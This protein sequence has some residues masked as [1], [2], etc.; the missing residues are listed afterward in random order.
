MVV[1][2]FDYIQY[3]HLPHS[4]IQNSKL[5][6]WMTDM[7]VWYKKLV[8]FFMRVYWGWW[9][10]TPRLHSSNSYFSLLNFSCRHGLHCTIFSELTQ[11]W[12]NEPFKNVKEIL[13]VFFKEILNSN[14]NISP[15]LSLS[16]SVKHISP[17]L[18]FLSVS[19]MNKLRVSFKNNHSS[20]L[21][22]AFQLERQS[23]SS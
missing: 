21:K 8:L 20:Y 15:T 14:L 4:L 2:S 16:I 6:H 11:E 7:K 1:H 10:F 12:I 13:F 5:M 22:K 19:V 9:T 23:E 17:N 18:N 3:F